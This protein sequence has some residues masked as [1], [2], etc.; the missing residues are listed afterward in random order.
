MSAKAFAAVGFN[1]EQR[2]ENF[3][4]MSENVWVRNEKYIFAKETPW[5][6]K[7]ACL[8]YIGGPLTY[9]DVKTN[10]TSLVGISNLQNPLNCRGNTAQQI[11]IKYQKVSYILPWLQQHAGKYESSK[12]LK[13]KY[14]IT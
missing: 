10:V 11:E 14:F 3:N 9:L 2:L 5:K 6:N 8:G 12:S 1:T 4:P 7:S 13:S